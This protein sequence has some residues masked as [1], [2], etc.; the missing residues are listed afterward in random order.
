M[1][2]RFA[3]SCDS[4]AGALGIQFWVERERV[5]VGK[6][7]KKTMERKKGDEGRERA[8]IL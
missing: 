1:G 4:V 3:S 6:A 7:G 5:A 8:N 2:Q